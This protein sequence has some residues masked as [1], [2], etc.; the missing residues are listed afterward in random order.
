MSWKDKLQPGSFRGVAFG[1]DS[2]ELTAGRRV[3]THEY[4][5][6]DK[7]YTEDLGR[8][9]RKISIEAFLIGA[10]YMD[11]RDKLLGALETA[12]PGELVHPWHGRMTVNVDGE[13]RVRHSR[14]DGGYCVVTLTLVESGEVAFP[15]ATNAPGA[16]SLLAADAV[17]KVSIETF[18]KKFSIDNLPEFS[19]LDAQSTAS[20][21]L[22]TMG[23]SLEKVGGVLA[24]PV[25]SLQSEL[26]SLL[27]TPAAFAQRLFGL[28]AKGGAVLS[29]A[30]RLSGMTDSDTI[31]YSRTAVTL[32]TVPQFVPAVRSASITPTRTRMLDNR[33][34]LATLNRRALLTQAAG[35]SA[36]MPMPVHDDAVVLRRELLAALDAEAATADDESFTALMTLRS[37][38]HAD[39]TARV[40]DS[41]RLTEITPREVTPALALAYDLYETTDRESEI[42]ARNR[43]RHPGFVPAARLKV[44]AA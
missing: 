5:Q 42:V 6:R 8:A 1:V 29:S 17:Q 15:A 37:K 40:R 2:G 44:I 18:A 3:Q 25:S 12:G 22:D 11:A 14:A 33:D 20:S 23:L 21:M 35:M 39:I 30:Q 43:L 28:F 38:V 7:P 10:D 13:C 36:A 27:P 19:V 24:N 31:N 32:R 9:T 26:T 16:Q 41:S 4:P 34:A